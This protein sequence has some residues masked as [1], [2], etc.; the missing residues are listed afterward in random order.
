MT[1][2]VSVAQ[3]RS[4][5]IELRLGVWRRRTNKRL[6]ARCSEA[7]ELCRW[8]NM[9]P[10]VP[11]SGRKRDFLLQ[12]GVPVDAFE[13]FMLLNFIDTVLAESVVGIFDQKLAN[14]VFRCFCQ[15]FCGR[16]IKLVARLRVVNIRTVFD[17]E[18][19]RAAE[20]L[21]EDDAEGPVVC[22]I[23]HEGVIYS[24]WGDVAF[25]A[26]QRI[27]AF[28]IHSVTL[29]LFVVFC[30]KRIYFVLY[31]FI[32]YFTR[33]KVDQLQVIVFA[34]DYVARFKVSVQDAICT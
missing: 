22:L 14:Q 7:C 20:Q 34:Q 24:F 4:C 18:R 23:A 5:T 8:T 29:I 27:H 3:R 28:Q 26:Y 6:V 1:G 31:F 19:H 30:G 2:I 13:E 15:I 9:L 33:A 10:H 11:Q 17:A 32:E 21:V 16:E 25:S 12:D